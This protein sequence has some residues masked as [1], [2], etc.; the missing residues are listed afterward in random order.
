M[1]QWTYLQNRNRLTDVENKLMVMGEEGEG[2]LGDWDWYIHTSINI[3]IR[4]N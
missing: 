4:D 1:V 2:K 3:C